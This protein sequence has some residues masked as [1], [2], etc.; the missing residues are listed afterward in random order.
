MAVILKLEY[1]LNLL[2]ESVTSKL[3]TFTMLVIIVM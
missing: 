1:M 2:D 3:R